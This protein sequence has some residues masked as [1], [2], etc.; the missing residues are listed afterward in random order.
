[1]DKEIELN[2]HQENLYSRQIGTYG[3]EIMR[4]IIHLKILILGLKGVGI[5]VAKNIILT[6]PELVTIY[7]DDF[8][9]INHLGTNYYLSKKEINKNKID[10]ICL[11]SLKNLNPYT[12]VEK[13]ILKNPNNLYEELCT[14]NFDVI[15]ETEFRPQNQIIMIY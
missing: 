9:N 7:D 4:K 1:M 15:V 13:L 10:E 12:K 3:E 6:G 8:V 2:K 5:E 14:R 11:D